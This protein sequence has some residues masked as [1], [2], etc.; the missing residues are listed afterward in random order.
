M[1]FS[2]GSELQRLRAGPPWALHSRWRVGA[3][4][5]AACGHRTMRWCL[6]WNTEHSG[7]SGG[8][9]GVLYLI[10]TILSRYLYHI[11]CIIPAKSCVRL[12]MILWISNDCVGF[13]DVSCSSTSTSE[14]LKGKFSCHGTFKHYPSAGVIVE[15]VVM[16]VFHGTMRNNV[17][18]D[19]GQNEQL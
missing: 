2:L 4:P 9:P 8:S 15:G 13:S 10:N 6:Q 12:R 11:I 7:C 16:D 17:E 19:N 1:Q 5:W 14:T 3:W 18:R